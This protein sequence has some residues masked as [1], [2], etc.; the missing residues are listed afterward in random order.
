MQSGHS[1]GTYKWFLK[2][3]HVILTFIVEMAETTTDSVINLYEANPSPADKHLTLLWA[4]MVDIKY[5]SK[6]SA[7]QS[8]VGFL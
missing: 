4:I 7:R 1:D 5:I 8:S 6:G 2:L 3:Y